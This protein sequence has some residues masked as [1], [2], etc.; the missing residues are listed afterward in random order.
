MSAASSKGASSEALWPFDTTKV[1]TAPA[2]AAYTD[3]LSLVPLVAAYERVLTLDALKVALA[4]GYPVTFGFRVYS[5]FTN[6]ATTGI[7]TYPASTETLLGGHAVVAVGYDNST[8]MVKCRNSYGS[9][10]GKSGYFFMP[11]KWFENMSGLVSDAWIIRP[12][13]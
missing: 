8:G 5:S 10:W 2:A 13:V 7:C 11:Y 4:S 6:T 3:G 12:K 1:L 9:T